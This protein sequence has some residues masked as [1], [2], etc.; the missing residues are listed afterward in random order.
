MRT[1]IWVALSLVAAFGA[2]LFAATK[3]EPAGTQAALLAEDGGAP[4]APKTAMANLSADGGPDQT[5]LAFYAF[6]ADA[7]LFRS[8][9]MRAP[10]RIDAML[11]AYR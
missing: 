8:V 5:Y 3:A 4:P 6:P 11:D 7:S 1:K 2:G 9:R 10:E